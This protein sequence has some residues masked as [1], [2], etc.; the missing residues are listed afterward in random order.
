MAVIDYTSGGSPI[1]DGPISLS[2]PR[3]SGQRRIKCRCG[4]SNTPRQL[5]AKG[6]T[7]PH[8]GEM[9]GDGDSNNSR[10]DDDAY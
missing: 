10:Y 4:H 2:E 7:C 3:P 8:C 9:A 6:G 1:H 5:R